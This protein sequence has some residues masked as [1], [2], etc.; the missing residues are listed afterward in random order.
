MSKRAKKGQD[1][2]EFLF[3]GSLQDDRHGLMSSK[4]KIDRDVFHISLDEFPHLATSLEM[5]RR[6]QILEVLKAR[7]VEAARLGCTVIPFG[8]RDLNNM[9][10]DLDL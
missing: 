5:L 4:F 3:V 2:P 7:I 1:V 9:A 6:K 10:S 8:S